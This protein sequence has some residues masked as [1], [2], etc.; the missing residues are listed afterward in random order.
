MV[1]LSKVVEDW[2]TLYIVNFWRLGYLLRSCQKLLFIEAEVLEY[3]GRKVVRC[4]EDND[5]V[6]VNGKVDPEVDIDIIN[7][8]LAF[9]DMSQVKYASH[10]Y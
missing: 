2:L 9:A 6:H 3:V 5:I 10:L 8:E 1:L 7:L 4:F